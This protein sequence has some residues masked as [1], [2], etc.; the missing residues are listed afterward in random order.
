MKIFG[1]V[2]KALRAFG[3]LGR[4][5]V[6][7]VV[8]AGFVIESFNNAARLAVCVIAVTAKRQKSQ[9]LT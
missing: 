2:G 7:T 8:A 9:M 4:F 3:A 1:V 5:N 6:L